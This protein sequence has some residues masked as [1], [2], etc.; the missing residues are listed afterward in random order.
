MIRIYVGLPRQGKTLNMV[1]DVLK[2]MRLGRRVIS[3]TPIW[4]MVN[5]RKVNAEF[6]DDPDEYRFHFL[7]A[8]GAMVVCDEMSLYFSSMRWSKLSMDFNAKFRQAGKMSCDLYGTSQDWTDTVNNLRKIVDWT[9]T[10]RKSHFLLPFPI[11]F[12]RE[13][14]DKKRQFFTKKGFYFATPIIYRMTRVAKSFFTSKATL[15]KNRQRFIFGTRTLYPSD[16][17]PVYASYDHEYQIT[18]SAVAT[19]HVFGKNNLTYRA[20]KEAESY[21]NGDSPPK[22]AGERRLVPVASASALNG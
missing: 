2:H 19:L 11:D 3:N 15:G 1:Y 7:Q 8:R 20:I 22:L 18:S 21:R 6:Y 17:R 4:C 10:C 12:R 9:A 14:Y 5:G 13:V 16:Y